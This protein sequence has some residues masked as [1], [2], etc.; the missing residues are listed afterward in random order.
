MGADQGFCAGRPQRQARPAT[1][2]RLFLDALLWMARSGSRWRDLP[3]RFGD[4]R[5]VKR[6]YYRWIEMGVLDECWRFWGAR[7]IWNG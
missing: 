1:D 5:S 2:N 4:Y 3:E 6:R 7:P